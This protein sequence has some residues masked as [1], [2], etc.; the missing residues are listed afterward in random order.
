MTAITK[1]KNTKKMKALLNMI[2]RIC[3]STRYANCSDILGRK[4]GG[5]RDGNGV[6]WKDPKTNS[7]G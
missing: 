2:R 7:A 1:Q 6:D 4:S 5:V 3:C